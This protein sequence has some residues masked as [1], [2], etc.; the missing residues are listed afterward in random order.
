MVLTRPTT[1]TWIAGSFFTN[2][3]CPAE[4]ADEV[5]CRAELGVADGAAWSR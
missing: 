2:P 5:A 4:V 3:V 1:T